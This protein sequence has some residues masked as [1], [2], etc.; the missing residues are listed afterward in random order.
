[1]YEAITTPRATPVVTPEQLAS[2]A[3]FDCPPQYDSL[4]PV[5]PDVDYQLLQ[6]FIDAASDKVEELAAT[7]MI[8]EGILLTFDFFP[9]QADPRQLL[10]Y[11]LGYA[12]QT[13]APWW[14]SGF[15]QRIQSSWC[16][17][18]CRRA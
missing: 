13:R 2:F 5:V 17:V 1:M 14:W 8:A 4:S 9:G 10:Q 12:Y 18:R 15:R 16:A 3:R 6:T 11:Q 7:A